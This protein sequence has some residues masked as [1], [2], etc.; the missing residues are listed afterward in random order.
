MPA[1]ALLKEQ[2]PVGQ[3]PFGQAVEKAGKLKATSGLAAPS[4]QNQ[5]V[6]KGVAS[7]L[8]HS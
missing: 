6:A 4:P 3:G 2:H 7:V 8:S 1:Q 5:G